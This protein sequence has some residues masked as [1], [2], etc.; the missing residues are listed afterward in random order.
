MSRHKQY[1]HLLLVDVEMQDAPE[2]RQAQDKLLEW[3][4]T[5]GHTSVEHGFKFKAVGVMTGK[6]VEPDN[7]DT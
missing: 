2:S 4:R 3:I 5:Y 7:G 1:R 6:R